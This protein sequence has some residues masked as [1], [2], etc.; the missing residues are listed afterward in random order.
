VLLVDEPLETHVVEE[1]SPP[2]HL[3][4]DHPATPIATLGA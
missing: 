3:A 4:A 1:A 2:K